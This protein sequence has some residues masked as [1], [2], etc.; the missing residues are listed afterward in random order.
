VDEDVYIP[1][2]PCIS[3]VLMPYSFWSLAE[4]SSASFEREKKFMATFEPSAANFWAM[5]APRP[6]CWALA[7]GFRR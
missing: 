6:L 4:S 7:G 5:T 3:V 2:S 1:A